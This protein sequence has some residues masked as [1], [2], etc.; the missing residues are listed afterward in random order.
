M[1]QAGNGS[2]RIR[3]RD[4]QQERPTIRDR[5]DLLLGVVATLEV[6]FRDRLLYRE[7]GFPIVELR[8]ELE[9]WL[10]HGFRRHADFEFRSMESDEDGFVWFRRVE[11][12]WRIGSIHQEFPAIEPLSAPEVW[13]IVARFIEDVDEWVVRHLGARPASLLQ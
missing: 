11:D 2:A 8:T 10:R 7:D 4:A 3:F 1:K 13:L 9:S 12:G 6:D 5:Y